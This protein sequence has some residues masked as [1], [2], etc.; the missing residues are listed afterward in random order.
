[1]VRK[2]AWELIGG[3]DEGFRPVWFEDVDFCKRLRQEGLR[4]VYVPS[5]VARHR[6]GHSANKVTWASRQI[7][8]YGSLLRYA[9][10][11]FPASSRRIVS[12]AVAVA[13]IPRM[14]AAVLLQRTLTPVTV[15]S[16]VMWLAGKSLLANPA[17]ALGAPS[18]DFAGPSA[19]SQVVEKHVQQ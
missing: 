7:Y 10:K 1:M 18:R 9:A 19:D 14:I 12:I 13:C 2:A 11:H 3:F 6:G 8:W 4:I 16:K 5:A 17:G 15:Y